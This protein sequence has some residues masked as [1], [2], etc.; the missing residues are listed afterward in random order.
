MSIFQINFS[1][2]IM[3]V[4]CGYTEPVISLAGDHMNLINESFVL[5]ITYHLYQF[6]EFMTDVFV[7]EKV[8]KSMIYITFANIAL[9]FSVV[10]IQNVSRLSWKCKTKWLQYK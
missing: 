10:T 4:V 8:G 7:R 6:T 2:L 1:A 9:N 3:L 5:L